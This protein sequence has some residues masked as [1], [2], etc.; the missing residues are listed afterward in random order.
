MMTMLLLTPIQVHPQGHLQAQLSP[1][2]PLTDYQMTPSPSRP[3]RHQL[4]PS[5]PSRNNLNLERNY[6]NPPASTRTTHVSPRSTTTLKPTATPPSSTSTVPSS[7]ARI[8]T[9]P[10]E[11]KPMRASPCPTVLL[12]FATAGPSPR[13]CGHYLWQHVR[14][15]RK[16]TEAW[17]VGYSGRWIEGKGCGTLNGRGRY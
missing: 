16:R 1:F 14:P 6:T 13:F 7:R 15:S 9:H 10:P 11:S 8:H 3:P 5:A 12:P 4:L 2:T 17:R